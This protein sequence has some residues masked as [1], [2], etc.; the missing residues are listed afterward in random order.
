MT[1]FRNEMKNYL[2]IIKKN[3]SNMKNLC[4]LVDN[5]NSQMMKLF[6]NDVF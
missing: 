3:I 2:L 4:H 6:C 1:F 5:K